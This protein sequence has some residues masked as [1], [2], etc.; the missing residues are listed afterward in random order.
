MIS[1]GLRKR[2]VRSDSTEFSTLYLLD[3]HAREC[4]F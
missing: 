3:I 4:H 1:G 2:S